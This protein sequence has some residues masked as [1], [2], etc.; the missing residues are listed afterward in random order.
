MANF[1]R[2]IDALEIF[3]QVNCVGVKDNWIV[4]GF[5]DKSKS[6]IIPS[7]TIGRTAFG[8][9]GYMAGYEIGRQKDISIS[10]VNGYFALLFNFTE[11]GVGIIP[12]DG[13]GLSLNPKKLVPVYD[14]FV[15]YSYQEISEISVKDFAGIRK[16]IKNVSISL[17]DNRK[18]YFFIHMVEKNLPYQ[19]VNMKKIV[20]RFQR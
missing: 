4:G 8:S 16:G 13:K 12:L 11:N 2:Y 15:F 18:L 9:A 5:I 6:A 14:S 1:D 7:T 20:E 19:E 17:V 10:K 3:K